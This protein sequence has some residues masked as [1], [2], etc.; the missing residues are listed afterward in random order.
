[1]FRIAPWLILFISLAMSLVQSVWGSA[2]AAESSQQSATSEFSW[3]DDNLSATEIAWLQQHPQLKLGIDRTFA[4]YEWVD[5]NGD[6]TGISADYFALLEQR[7]GVSF[8]PVT[9]KHSWGE[10]LKAARNG[11]FDLMSCMVK[12]AERETY[13]DFSQPYLSSTAV[14]ISEQSKGYIGTLDKLKGKRV[15]IHKGHFTNELLRRDYPEITII[16]PATIQDA[17]RMVA[18]GE[19]V[20]FVGDATAAGFVMKQEGILNL[21]FSG[22]TDYQSDFRI[23]VYRGNPILSGIIEKALNSITE[24]E[25][26]QI[27]EHWAGLTVSQNGIAVEKILKVSGLVLLV[28]LFILYWN[29]RLYRSEEAHRKS[30]K[31]F[32]N[33]VDT[34]NGIV[35]EADHDTYTYTYISDNVV[36]VLGYP[37]GTWFKPNFWKDHIHPD[38]RE[39]AIRFCD[40]AV[41]DHRDHEFE[42]RF[43][44]ANGDIVW[45]RDMVNVVVEDGKPRWLRGLMLDI[46]D[47]KMADMLIRQ[48]ET[49]F[50]ELIESLPAIAVQGYDENRQVIYWNDASETLYGYSREEALGQP[51]EALIIP[52][53]MRETVIQLHHDWLE[54]GQEIPASEL[55]L[56]HKDGSLVPVFSSHVMLRSENDRQEMYCIDVNLIEQKRA[57]AELTRM[58]H[59]DSLTHLP[60]RR[61]FTDRLLQ[62]M[63]KADRE[64]E[65][66]AVMM[67][68][69]DRFKEVNDTLGHDY[70][71]LLLQG[72]AKRLLSCVRE[73][74]TVA[75]LGG[76]EFLV[77][78]GNIGD[79]SVIERVAGN[80]L[81]QLGEPFILKDNRSFVSA[82]IGI[83]LYPSDAMTLEALMK[84]AD[85]AMYAAKEEG[86]NRFHYFTP[87]MEAVAQQRRRLLNEL[88]EALDL[89]QFEVYYQPILDLQNGRVVKAEALLRWNH[90]RGQVSPLDFIPLAEETGLIVD[91]GNW[92]FAEVVRQL[93]IWQARFNTELQVSVNTSPVQ[94]QDD[95]SSKPNWFGHVLTHN[96]AANLCV[97]I[98]ESLLM[99]AGRGVADKLLQFR[100]QG[101]EV[102]L[103]DFG[104]GYSSLAYLKQFHI[105]Y[106]KI[107]QSFVS[108]LTSG[109][110]D[111]V[112]C[113]AIIVMAH[114]LDIKVI[115]E[116][117]ETPEQKQM[118]LDI[119]CDFG[120][121][122]LFGR[123]VPAN[124]FSARWLESQV[125]NE[126]E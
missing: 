59:Y 80:I 122:Y 85:Q 69:L 15:A 19:A 4:P 45:L 91:I 44:T 11:E 55:E 49:R 115:A 22:H 38:D 36:R 23:G 75:R 52:Q 82:S 7:L 48:S 29:F 71:D 42:Y 8:V 78:L 84:N 32:K 123:P 89:Q 58:A 90:P 12:T 67:I 43:L 18:E 26:N 6:Y 113:E 77:I 110:Q 117:V 116:G 17:L 47:Q 120:Q 118:L 56:Q 34:T 61:T 3:R 121:G 65:Q 98:T 76:D 114:T 74:D 72:A 31:R 101:I 35:W 9:D 92:V 33:L 125:I 102:A 28:L 93:T 14:I 66:V 37:I 25:R 5:N 60:N 41:A 70:G 79:L 124:E 68:D 73:T 20:A 54:K 107:D 126:V 105:D 94:Y 88:R 30:E 95:N 87:E 40:E 104:T 63:K 62:M 119:G 106:L 83:A 100:D 64:G 13:L 96:G 112:L 24:N 2:Y 57:R 27:F 103:D 10:V 53:A 1:M 97:E 108:H 109:S 16:N 39:W 99:E 86:R 51:L 81:R 21:S 50:R 46:T 111:L